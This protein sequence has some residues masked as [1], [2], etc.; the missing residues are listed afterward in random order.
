MD[1]QLE[2]YKLIEWLMDI[3]DISILNRLKKIKDSS[4]GKSDWSEEVSQIEIKLIKK[5][6]KDIENGN[7]SSHEDVMNQLKNKF[8]I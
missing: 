1:I 5:G 7:F 3:K 2:K 6:L 4:I 8:S